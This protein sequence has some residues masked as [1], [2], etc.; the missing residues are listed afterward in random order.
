MLQATGDNNGRRWPSFFLFESIR[1]AL[2]YWTERLLRAA[3]FS[4]LKLINFQQISTSRSVRKSILEWRQYKCERRRWWNNLLRTNVHSQK[5]LSIFSCFDQ[6][7]PRT[8]ARRKHLRMTNV[9]NA[10]S[11]IGGDN[12]PVKT[13]DEK[14]LIVWCGDRK[15]RMNK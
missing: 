11:S 8:M 9:S 14:I 15:R 3:D 12:R 13:V 5:M 7:P 6:S 2:M 10:T 1:H 4:I